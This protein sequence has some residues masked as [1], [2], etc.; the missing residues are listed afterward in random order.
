MTKGNSKHIPSILLDLLEHDFGFLHKFVIPRGYLLSSRGF[1]SSQAW[2]PSY[3][4]SFC[5]LSSG[6]A[7]CDLSGGTTHC[8]WA[9]PAKLAIYPVGGSEKTELPRGSQPHTSHGLASDF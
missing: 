4:R 6:R 1:L 3:L 7:T 5:A 2:V 9:K 8:S